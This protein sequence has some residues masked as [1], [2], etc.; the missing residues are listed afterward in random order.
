MTLF[1]FSISELFQLCE[2]KLKSAKRTLRIIR[3]RISADQFR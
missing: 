2:R 3:L 1:L